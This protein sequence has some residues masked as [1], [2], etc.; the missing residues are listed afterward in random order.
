[1]RIR[2][3]PTIAVAGSINRKGTNNEFIQNAPLRVV[4]SLKYSKIRKESNEK[5]GFRVNEMFSQHWNRLGM[6]LFLD[7]I[8]I[9]NCFAYLLMIDLYD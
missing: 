7:A 2:G 9:G 6:D 8:D 3:V 4:S 5:I 1:M